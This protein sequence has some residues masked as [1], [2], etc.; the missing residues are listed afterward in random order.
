MRLS[1]QVGVHRFESTQLGL[2]ALQMP[3]RRHFHAGVLAPRR[4]Y[5]GSLMPYFQHGSA[6]FAPAS[7]FLR[8]RSIGSSLNLNFCMQ[9]AC[10]GKLYF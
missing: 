4:N 1:S 3:Q 6:T 2:D 7:I 5:V 8:I 10:G 9:S